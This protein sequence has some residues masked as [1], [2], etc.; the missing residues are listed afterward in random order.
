M[1]TSNATSNDSNEKYDLFISYEWGS[2]SEVAQFQSK[3]EEK[4]KSLRVWRDSRL[5]SNN[6]SLYLQLGQQIRQSSLFLCLLTRAYT[7]S[8]MCK[9]ELNYA[10]KLG[11][12]IF[13]FMLEK[14]TQAEIG[15]EIGFI[16]GNCV[17]KQY[18]KNPKS[19]EPKK[20][21]RHVDWYIDYFDEAYELIRSNLD[22]NLAIFF[23]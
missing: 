8:E 16:L 4:D 7:K 17:Y 21:V 14:L 10:A 1:A 12:T 18:Y 20:D 23:F 9:K 11:K 5:E 2:K 15:D 19:K 13:C 6:K 3:L 22:V